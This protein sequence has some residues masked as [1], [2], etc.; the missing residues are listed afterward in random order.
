MYKVP[1]KSPQPDINNFI[2]II[3]G[4]I[5]PSR[6][7]VMEYLIDEE[8]RRKI[9]REL[10][11]LDWVEPLED[12]NVKD[13]YLKNYIQFW[14]RM[15]Y[16]YV[17]FETNIGFTEGEGRKTDD[18]ACLSRG[19]RQWAEEKKGIVTSW[20]D[21][22][23]Y[24]W[25]QIEDF[26]FSPYEFISQNLPRDMGFIVSHAGGVL[27][28]VTW[29]M[30]YESLSYALY[31]NSYLVKA[32]FD[33]VGQTIYKFYK[34]IVEIPN[35]YAFFQGDDMGFKT[36]T[37]I[38]P[39]ILRKYVLPWHKKY[40]Q[41][42]HEHNMLYLLHSCGNIEAIMDDL[43]EDVG[44][45]GKHSFE[46]EIMPVNKFCKKY[47]DKIAVLGG[48]DI[49]VLATYQEDDLRKYIRNNLINCMAKGKYA[50]GSGN[51]ISNYIPVKNYLVMLE[52]GLNFKVS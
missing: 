15:G 30:G 31:D 7:V 13:K 41:L 6:G 12:S 51:S 26:D 20:K 34:N 23:N 14:Y 17:R 32:I 36:A 48:V 25:P 9:S 22:E 21:F 16:D 39:Q 19:V 37:L 45:D 38:S 4:E 28:N 24:K 18:T 3:K 49:N 27:E 40:A 46:D 1:L 44:I 5:I 33:K 47:S 8:V 42:A 29:L 52:E 50:L 35:I 10:L 11:G 43:I 2:R